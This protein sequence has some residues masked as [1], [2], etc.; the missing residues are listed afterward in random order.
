MDAAC[1]DD[2]VTTAFFGRSSQTGEPWSRSSTW[3]PFWKS[4]AAP[5]PQVR[6]AQGHTSL[7]GSR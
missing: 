4:S 7:H 5:K 2:N 1:D 6:R 3:R